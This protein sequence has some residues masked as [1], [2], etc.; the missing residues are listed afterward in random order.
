MKMINIKAHF[1]NHYFFYVVSLLIVLSGISS[2]FRFMVNNDYM[3]SYE[4]EC[5]P[6][7][8]TCFLGCEDDECTESYYYTNMQKYA[9][10]LYRQCGPDITGC[11]EAN[12]CLPEDYNCS[13]TYC[14][15]EV[16]GEGV[17]S[18]PE[19]DSNVEDIENIEDDAQEPTEEELLPDDNIINVNI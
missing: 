15:E 2:Y 1:S 13:I 5:D 19:E 8:D 11:E 14:D 4:G 12:I 7:V 10:D 17:C 16:E 18:I 3:V 6:T 9:A